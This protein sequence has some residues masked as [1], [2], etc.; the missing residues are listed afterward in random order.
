MR[1]FAAGLASAGKIYLS[2]LFSVNASIL[3]DYLLVWRHYNITA[4]GK[5]LVLLSVKVYFRPIK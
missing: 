3:F 2:V 4:S 1:D 5:K